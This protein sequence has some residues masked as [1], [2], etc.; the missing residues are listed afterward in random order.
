MIDLTV[1][2]DRPQI[3]TT[4]IISTDATQ[5][6]DNGNDAGPGEDTSDCADSGDEDIEDVR[7]QKK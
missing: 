5:Q 7:R 6:H 2:E 1:N 3:K 4:D